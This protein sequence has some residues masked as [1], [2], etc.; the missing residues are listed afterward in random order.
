V[1]IDATDERELLVETKLLG[2]FVQVSVSDSGAGLAPEVR[3]QLFQP[4]VTTKQQGMGLGLSICRTI[5]EAHGGKIWVDE[6][7]GGGTIFRFTLPVP[8]RESEEA[9]RGQ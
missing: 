4:F 3:A 9:A 1:L 7:P 2:A 6:R 8:G 5:I